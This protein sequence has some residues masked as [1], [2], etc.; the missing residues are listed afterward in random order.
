MLSSVYAL[1]SEGKN[2]IGAPQ[3]RSFVADFG[4]NPRHTAIVN[5]ILDLGKRLGHSVIAEGIESAEC[6][7]LLQEATCHEGQGYHF[8]KPMARTDM[9]S[10]L[11]AKDHASMRLRAT[12]A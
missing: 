11:A 2:F 9:D 12:A 1:S 8:G 7:E 6:A 4:S 3:Y 10:M 5:A